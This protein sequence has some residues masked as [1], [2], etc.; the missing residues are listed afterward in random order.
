VKK[1]IYL[2][3]FGCQMN[4]KDAEVMAGL[5]GQVGYDLSGTEENAEVIVFVTCSVRQHA[6]ERVW[7]KLGMIAKAR[8]KDK[9]IIALCG[10]MAQEHKEKAFDKLSAIDIVCGP[11]NMTELPDLV[12]LALAGNSRI[13]AVD[14]E[15]RFVDGISLPHKQGEKF[16]YVNI[17]YGC[18]NYCAYCVVPY[19]RGREVSR[20][21]ENIVGEVEALAKGGAE[22]VM[23]LGQN[24]NSY[25]I[26][27]CLPA[28]R[29]P[30]AAAPRNDGQK[31]RP[32]NDNFC[33][34]LE[35]L[36]EIEGL[37]KI[38]FTT[39]HPKDAGEELFKAMKDL[40]KVEKKLHLPV[41]SGSNK[42]L[43]AMKRGY[44]REEYLAKVDK[45][46]ELIPN[47]VV[48]S[49]IIVGFP[50]E[51][52]EDFQDTVDLVKKVRFNN[53]YIFKY[54]PRPFTAAAKLSDD[55]PKKTKEERNQVLLELQKSVS[56]SY[57]A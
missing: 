26:A 34:L 33:M 13:L 50:G 5:L 46:R 28:G 51:S 18:N 14:K 57:K 11:A 3:T 41:Q 35:K 15:T 22:E 20:A 31:P 29:R 53:A 17:M 56:R 19:V 23:L 38:S 32:R 37:K 36:N 21:M 10:C 48:A 43:K 1:S 49:D 27:S 24:V 44:T 42:I 4:E 7:G 30:T 12:K 9:P 52:E 39:S 6:E 25:E 54:S 40:D 55:V 2:R 8:K 16:A 47:C 45:L